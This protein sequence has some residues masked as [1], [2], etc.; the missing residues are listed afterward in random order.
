MGVWHFDHSGLPLAAS[1][2]SAFVS[3]A[4]RDAAATT[5]STASADG[6]RV[7]QRVPFARLHRTVPDVGRA[8]R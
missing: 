8:V 6:V 2:S 4:A 1:I 3:A 7:L 5:T